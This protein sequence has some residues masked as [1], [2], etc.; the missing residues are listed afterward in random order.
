MERIRL[1]EEARKMVEEYNMSDE[2]YQNHKE[3]FY[4]DTEEFLKKWKES[5][6]HLRWMLYFYLRLSCEVYEQYQKDNISDKIFNDTFY[7]ITIWCE[8]CYRKYG[9][10]GMEEAGW[11]AVSVKMRLYRLGR[12]QFEPMVLDEALKS[13]EIEVPAGSRVLNVH[14]P[15]GEKMDYQA[16][17]ESFKQAEEF[18]GDCYIAYMCDSWLLDPALKELLSEASNIIRFQNLFKNVKVTYGY[19][20]AEERIFKDV[21]EDKENYPE[22]SSLQRKTKAYILAGKK[23]GMGIGAFYK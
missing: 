14:I 8:E 10:R 13:A 9:I 18:F 11:I 16:C 7:D 15:A 6:D 19:P 22:E 20:Q 21:R 2:E 12:L 1:P 23:L 4:Q 3:L 17:L 5:E